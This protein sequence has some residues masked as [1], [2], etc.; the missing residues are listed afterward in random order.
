MRPPRQ[1]RS[2]ETL[3]RLLTA[4]EE[5]IEELGFEKATVSGIVK[6][7]G[8]S[9]G[10]FYT[11]FSDKDA[12]LRCLL[13]RFVGEAIA[14]ID[15]TMRPAIWKDSSLP[16][17]VSQLLFF[18]LSSLK[19]RH[20]FLQAIN[21]LTSEEPALASYRENITGH[22]ATQL[23]LLLQSHPNYSETVS[24]RGLKMVTWM[25]MSVIESSI[26]PGSPYPDGPKRNE[27]IADLGDMILAYLEK[28]KLNLKRKRV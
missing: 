22:C 26:F 1:Q 19:E 16:E 8:S 12:L 25:S 27:L 2:Q 13:D 7:A 21:R 18:A 5:L 17:L 4:T 23:G 6:R 14:T 24:E 10:A 28:E 11:R 15:S 3:E 9:V 20:G